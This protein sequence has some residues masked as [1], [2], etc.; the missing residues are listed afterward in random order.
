MDYRVP[1]RDNTYCMSV[2]DDWEKAQTLHNFLELSGNGYDLPS[3]LTFE[4]GDKILILKGRELIVRQEFS[5]S[6]SLGVHEAIVCEAVSYYIAGTYLNCQNKDPD[7]F[8]IFE[9][10][11]TLQPALPFSPKEIE[12]NLLTS[13]YFS[14][15]IEDYFQ[16]TPQ[17]HQIFVTRNKVLE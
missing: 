7:F 4:S 10:R 15:N 1:V 13:E 14:N 11:F 9:E 8:R 12:Q 2:Y 3:T 5:L 6:V 17:F 16:I